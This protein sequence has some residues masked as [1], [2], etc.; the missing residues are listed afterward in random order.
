VAERG[1][2][3]GSGAVESEKLDIWRMAGFHTCLFLFLNRE[4]PAF[5]LTPGKELKSGEQKFT[6]SQANPSL[7]SGMNSPS[8]K[9]LEMIAKRVFPDHFKADPQG[10]TCEAFKWWREYVNGP[11]QGN[12]SRDKSRT[13]KPAFDSSSLF[14][15]FPR[16]FDCPFEYTRMYLFLSDETNTTQSDTVQFLIFGAMVI[17]MENAPAAVKEVLEIRQCYGYP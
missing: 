8:Q 6:R 14:N 9:T 11:P 5:P 15:W 4:N 16:T 7:L 10:T 12:L 17:P 3:I 13:G 2:P 1:A